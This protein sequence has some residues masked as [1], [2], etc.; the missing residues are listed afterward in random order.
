MTNQL[1][2]QGDEAVKV[3]FGREEELIPLL[4]LDCVQCSSLALCSPLLSSLAPRGEDSLPNASATSTLVA[5][6]S[7]CRNV[8]TTMIKLAFCRLWEK[9]CE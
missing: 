6:S 5:T 4:G 1:I 9:P 7:L 3:L 8:L 2:E